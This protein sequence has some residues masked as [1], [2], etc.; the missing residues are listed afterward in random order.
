MEQKILPPLS[1]NKKLYYLLIS[2]ALNT[3]G[4]ALTV[5]MNMGSSMWT[6]GSVNVARYLSVDLGWILIGNATLGILWNIWLDK[7]IDWKFIAGNI[8]FVLPFSTLVQLWVGLFATLGLPQL[9]WLVRLVLDVFGIFLIAIAVSIYQRVN[10][11]IHPLDEVTNTLRFRYCG[12]NPVKAQ[13][14]NFSVPIAVMCVVFALSG[15]LDAVN[16]GTIAVLLFQG[17]WIGWAD[18][19]IFPTLPHYFRH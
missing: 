13:L 5:S 18:R 12:G 10:W 4:N 3:F 14:L 8:A 1:L 2:I 17:A 9:P 19:Y 11:I 6:A 7:K 15:R 16:I